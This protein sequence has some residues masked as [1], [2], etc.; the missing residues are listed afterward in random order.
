MKV[1][2][3]QSAVAAIATSA[4]AAY[5]HKLGYEAEW[6]QPERVASEPLGFNETEFSDDDLSVAVEIFDAAFGFALQLG[7][8]IG[9]NPLHTPE[10]KDLIATYRYECKA[11]EAA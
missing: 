8:R 9:A 11:R 10:I 4:L 3:D 6:N 1:T 7:A 5:P 2:I